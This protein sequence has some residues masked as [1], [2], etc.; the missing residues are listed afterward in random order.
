[1]QKEIGMKQQKRTYKLADTAVLDLDVT[2]AVEALLVGILKKAERSKKPRGGWAPS[3]DSKA[4]KAVEEAP[5]WA[6]A[7]AEAPAMRE[8]MAASLNMVGS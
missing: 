5:C 8:A 3:S 6:G 7:K 4:F 1:M 2:E